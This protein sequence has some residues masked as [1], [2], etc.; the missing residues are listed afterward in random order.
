MTANLVHA[1]TDYWIERAKFR[2]KQRVE[3]E[4]HLHDKAVT[5]GK[6]IYEAREAGNRIEDIMVLVGR[7]NKSFI[8]EMLNIFHASRKPEPEVEPEPSGEIEE[9]YSFYKN[10]DGNFVVAIPNENTQIL[11]RNSI[12]GFDIPNDWVEG[13]AEQRARYKTILREIHDY[14]AGQK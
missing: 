8:Y 1:Y 4:K 13:D 3:L 11:T 14:E 5:L 10:I 12:G 6:A 2:A 9:L 7:K